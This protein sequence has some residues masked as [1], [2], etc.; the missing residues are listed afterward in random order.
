MT[1]VMPSC[2]I[3]SGCRVAPSVIVSLR[4]CDRVLFFRMVLRFP[5]VVLRVVHSSVA[6]LFIEVY[7]R[8]V[9]R[10]HYVK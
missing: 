10:Y 1:G 9:V 6:E 8:N 7:S 2:N 5:A 3:L 4:F